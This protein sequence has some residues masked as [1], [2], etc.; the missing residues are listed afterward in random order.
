MGTE[1]YKDSIFISSPKSE[2]KEKLCFSSVHRKVSNPDMFET[3]PENKWTAY[4]KGR[5][6]LV[7]V[8]V[9]LEE[10]KLR[11]PITVPY[12]KKWIT[13]S[14]TSDIIAEWRL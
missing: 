7:K 2:L 9:K 5:T 1:L 10:G 11:M 4:T 14:D 13:D 6:I 3:I 8:W 12:L